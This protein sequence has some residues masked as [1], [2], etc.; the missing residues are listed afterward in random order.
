M[1]RC[2]KIAQANEV[3]VEG[4]VYDLHNFFDLSAVASF[5]GEKCFRVCFRRCYPADLPAEE[6]VE[7]CIEISNPHRV[8]VSADILRG[9]RRDLDELGYKA[10]MDDDIEWLVAEEK[11]LEDYDLVLRFVGGGYIRLGGAVAKAFLI[12]RPEPVVSAFQDER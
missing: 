9:E 8:E 1:K 7:V 3:V 12:R 11:S 4:K 5:P 6:R 10:P 2:F